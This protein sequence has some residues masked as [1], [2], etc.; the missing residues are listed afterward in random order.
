LFNDNQSRTGAANKSAT[1]QVI[2]S[3]DDVCYQGNQ[4]RS[5]RT[6][7][8]LSNVYLGAT[9]LRAIGNRLSEAGTSTLMSLFTF[10]TRLN[11]TSLNQGDHCII[12]ADLD[13]AT[14]DYIVANQ[15]L[16]PSS[17]CGNLQKLA[18]TIGKP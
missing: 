5:E 1:C 9:T 12:G 4:S 13:P 14:P 2:T 8:L 11:N 10:S 18:T 15:V 7:N 3:L 17:L 16:N 6:S